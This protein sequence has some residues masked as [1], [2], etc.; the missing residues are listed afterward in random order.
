VILGFIN[1]LTDIF[2]SENYIL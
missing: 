2:Y 1:I